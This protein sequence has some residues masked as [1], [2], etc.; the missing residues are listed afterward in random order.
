MVIP[1]TPRHQLD[2]EVE[3]ELG[4]LNTLMYVFPH[5]A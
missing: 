3:R 5:F 2:P 4:G 1:L